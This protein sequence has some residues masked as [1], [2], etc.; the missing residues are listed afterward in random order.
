MLALYRGPFMADDVDAAW[1]L[2]ARERMRGRLERAMGRV[3]RYWQ[4]NG[5]PERASE[6]LERIKQSVSDR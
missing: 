6:C 4:E 1:V 3:L 2:Q 5:Q